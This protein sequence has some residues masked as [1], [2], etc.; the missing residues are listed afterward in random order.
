ML[1]KRS[2]QEKKEAR[3]EYRDKSSRTV[4]KLLFM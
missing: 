4:L 3:T 2:F 1:V